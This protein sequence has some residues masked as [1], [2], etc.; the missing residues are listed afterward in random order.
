MGGLMRLPDWQARLHAWLGQVDGRPVVP[1]RHDCCL[2]GASAVEVQTGVDLAAPW[3]GRYTTMAGGRRVLRKAGFADHVALLAAH[4]PEVH[5]AYACEGD[6]VVIDTPEG[7]A[8]GVF[9]G[10]AIYVLLTETG[11]L[12]LAPA[13]AGTI[14]FRVG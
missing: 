6:L 9:Q 8:V 7:P 11:K 4:L 12:G 2:F 3:R 1:G 10:S 13:E 5:P 14:F